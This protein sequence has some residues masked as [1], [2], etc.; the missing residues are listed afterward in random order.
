MRRGPKYKY[1][2]HKFY[3]HGRRYRQVARGKD[4]GLQ[5]SCKLEFQ[6]ECTKEI[7]MEAKKS[8]MKAS[9]SGSKDQQKPRMNP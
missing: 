8:F 6:L 3:D 5:G 9:T 7:F 4:M 1:D 2:A